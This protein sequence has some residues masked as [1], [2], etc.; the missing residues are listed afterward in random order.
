M[1]FAARRLARV[2]AIVSVVALISAAGLVATGDRQSPAGQAATPPPR[3]AP[4]SVPATYSN[5]AIAADGRLTFQF[6]GGAPLPLRERPPVWTLTQLRGSPRGT[7]TGIALDFGKPDFTGTLVYGLIPYHDTR[8]PQPVFRTTT[9]IK[10]GKA[11][12]NIK[13]VLGGTYDMVGWRQAG[14]GVVGYRIITPDGLMVHDGRVRFTGI[15]PFEID[16]AL[17]EGPFLANVTEK[18]AVVW[19]ELDRQADCAVEVLTRTFPCRPGE[20]RQEISIGELSPGTDYPYVVKYGGNKEQY[21]FR[22]ATKPGA[23]KPFLFG[24]ASDSRAGQGGGDR[25]FSGPNAYIMR[26][27]MAVAVSRG[28]AFVQFTGD[29]VS[30]Y[31]GSPEALT[32]ELANWKR[33]VEPYAHWL[34]LYTGIGNHEVVL[35]EF[36]GADGR[37]VRVDRFPYASESTEATFA[38]AMVNPEN[39]PVSEDGAVY[40][41]TPAAGDFPPYRENVYWFAHDNV[42]MVV[43][44][45]DYWFSPSLGGTPQSSGG[46]H[47]Y[48]MDNQMEWLRATLATL[49]QNK[50]IDHVFLTVHTPIFPNG[51]HVGDDMWYGG[52]NQARPWVAGKAVAKGILERRDELLTLIQASPKVVAVLTGDEHNYN[53]LELGPTVPIYP[54]DWT[55]PRVTLK[56]AFHQ[57]NNGAAGAPYYAQDVTPWSAFVKG[58]STQH[59]LCLFQVDGGRVRLEVVNPDTLEVLDRAVLR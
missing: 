20:T 39:G 30:G 36:V 48:L 18:S 29:L 15:G 50:A 14:R 49:Q 55:Q 59:A 34:P 17:A 12:I 2:L 38:R 19:F 3:E 1:T 8:H 7:D 23:R 35:R 57:V 43:L 11:E 31:V 10:E 16:V 42:A 32:V 25:N 45:S 41:P 27:L 54:P 33:A 51:G 40:D 53:R 56:R 4:P 52:K 21:A 13:A 6:E 58:F 9:P 37:T 5:I 26:R 28:A 44:N 24:Y 46:I 22:T 47:G